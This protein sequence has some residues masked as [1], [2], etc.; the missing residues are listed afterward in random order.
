MCLCVSQRRERAF[1]NINIINKALFL[2]TKQINS[3]DELNK[4]ILSR[5]WGKSS[6]R[7]RV[8]ACE[9][10]CVSACVCVSEAKQKRV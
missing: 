9:C 7:E 1:L 4:T 3:L 8:S 5:E 10:V 6:D 2:G